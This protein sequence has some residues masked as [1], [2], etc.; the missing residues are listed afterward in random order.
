MDNASATA[1]YVHIPFCERRCRYCAFESVPISGQDIPAYITAVLAEARHAATLLPISAST[2][3]LG[4]GTPTCLPPAD[5]CRLIERLRSL[6]RLSSSA[7]EVTVEA[8]PHTVTADL[9]HSLHSSGVTR[10]SLGV[11][12]LSRRAL[13]ALGRA[14]RPEDS[15]RG[16]DTIKRA[17][18]DLNID[19]IYGLPR[20]TL[21]HWENTLN[22]ITGWDPD[23]LSLYPLEVHDDTPLGQYRAENPRAFADDD[24]VADQFEL[25]RT[26]LADRFQHYELSNWCR[27]GHHSRHNL[28]YWK[29]TNYLGLGAAAHSHL[30]LPNGLWP[31]APQ[32]AAVRFH[33]VPDPNAY[34]QRHPGG[35]RFLSPLDSTV[36]DLIM[37][38]RLT[39]G[40]DL[41][42]IHR[43]RGVDPTVTFGHAITDLE[44][45]GLLA[46][47]IGRIRLTERALF[48]ANRVFTRFIDCEHPNTH[49][50]HP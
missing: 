42:Q 44:R 24:P 50:Y 43:R 1:I 25:A 37:G 45:E 11:Q 2:L 15:R 29:N 6:F 38:L 4:G 33:N 18:L 17:G 35:H 28:T 26:L 9:I 3:Y 31:A 20:M 40:V 8:N 14:H 21:S 32:L 41:R 47:E 36:D 23:H 48:V 46:R 10:I 27:P 39:D 22:E 13:A 5:L 12:S 34:I 19:L 16:A 49:P 7:A 30:S